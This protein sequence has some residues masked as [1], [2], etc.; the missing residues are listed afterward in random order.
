MEDAQLSTGVPHPRHALNS[1]CPP[2]VHPASSFSAAPRSPPLV[3]PA[4]HAA[5][6]RA[7]TTAAHHLLTQVQNKLQ[8][9]AVTNLI[10]VGDSHIE[11]DAVHLLGRSFA[12]ALV[13]TV[14]LWERPTPYELVRSLSAESVLPAPSPPSMSRVSPPLCPRPGLSTLRSC[15][16][17]AALRACL[18]YRSSSSRWSR[19]SCPKFTALARRSTS[20]LSARALCKAESSAVP[21]VLRRSKRPSRASPKLHRRTRRTHYRPAGLLRLQYLP[22][23]SKDEVS[24]GD[25]SDDRE[26]RKAREV[27]A[28]QLMIQQRGNETVPF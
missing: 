2:A 8:L 16:P 14:K 12:H 3:Q 15:P 25:D 1:G 22:I 6:T 21:L 5:R 19:R 7:A 17:D 23:I 27:G 20:G 18:P 28:H 26:K 13:K 9:E 4:A 24:G 10:S 11:M